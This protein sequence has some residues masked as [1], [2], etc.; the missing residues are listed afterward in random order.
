[1][2]GQ[3]REPAK[4]RLMP[5]P[6]LPFTARMARKSRSKKRKPRLLDRIA[7]RL[8]QGVRWALI[9]ALGLAVVLVAWVVLYR[10]V[11]PPGGYY[12]WQESRR[13]GGISHDW[14]DFD[15]IAPVMARSVVAAE[16]AN[17][18]RHYG[19]DVA[20]IRLALAEGAGRGAS[21]IT[22]QVVKNTFLWHGRSWLRKAL[23]A[24]LTPIVETLWTKQRILEVYLNMAEFGEGVF[25][26]Q[27]ASRR[28]FDR[29]AADPTRALVD[30]AQRIMDGA[31]TIAR[32]DRADC[33]GG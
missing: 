27:A 18:C 9:G 22:Q 17:F 14:V 3:A 20:A 32:D 31:A 30:R 15:A 2:P 29:D 12:M 19:F 16:D 11:D 5:D 24:V 23:E 7:T 10:F 6:A 4:R 1:M 28:H 25:G 21:T 26:V 13:L 33:F 8:R